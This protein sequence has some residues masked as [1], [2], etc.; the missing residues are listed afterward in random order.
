MLKVDTNKFEFEGDF[1]KAR[2]LSVRKYVRI[3]TFPDNF[4]FL[5]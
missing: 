4:I 2:R 1:N 3:Q 5:Q